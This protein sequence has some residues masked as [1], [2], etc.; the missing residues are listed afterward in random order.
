MIG[1]TIGRT[2]LG[3]CILGSFVPDDATM[4]TPSDKT[5]DKELRVEAKALL[6]SGEEITV[7]KVRTRVEEKLDL[8]EQFFKDSAKWKD[9]SK[10]IIH[11]AI[12][13]CV[14]SFHPKFYWE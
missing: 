6:D 5:L 13:R 3:H 2:T 10:D 12:V 11:K 9:R 1:L 7:N 14:P 8:P 4:P